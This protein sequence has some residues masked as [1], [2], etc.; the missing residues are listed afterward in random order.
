MRILHVIESLEIGGAEKVVIHLANCLSIEHEVTVCL[1]KS[2]G[3]LLGDLSKDINVICLNLGEG[4]HFK[5]PSLLS[6]IVRDKNIDI[7][8]V[9]NWGIFVE[10]C[11]AA[12]RTSSTMVVLTVHGLYTKAV[13]GLFSKSKR[14]LRHWLERHHAKSRR[15]GR[16]VTVSNAIQEYVTEE[17]G[18]KKEKLQTIHNGIGDDFIEAAI[19]N[20][21]CRL[22]T[23]GRLA[24]VKNQRLLLDAFAMAVAQNADM[25]L[26][27][28][29]DGP[30]RGALERRVVDLSLAKHVEFMGF[31]DNALQLVAQHNVFVLSSDY[32]GISIA[33][34]E[35]MSQ[36]LP[37]ITT[38]VGGI[39]EM[40]Q[41]GITG[42]LVPQGNVNDFSNAILKMANSRSLRVQM[43]LKARE[44]FLSNF[45]EDIVLKKYQ[46]VYLECV[47]GT[48]EKIP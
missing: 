12:K 19:P 4:I 17:V 46:Q 48:G 3:D 36:A 30:E 18:I 23:V 20:D 15:V 5:L 44:S 40:V 13:Q 16:I 8:N 25:H 26:T 32:E 24:A 39:P 41:H 45:H 14:M 47:G 29:G 43:G 34:L 22:I 2:S 10:C 6:A 38:S 31:R 35:A 27:I 7:V 9:H 33:L 37:A 11:I 21:S 42:L 28:V 1:V